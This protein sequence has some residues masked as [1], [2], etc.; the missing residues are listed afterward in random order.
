MSWE[1]ESNDRP[2]EL[3]VVVSRSP[4]LQPATPEL[5]TSPTPELLTS[6]TPAPQPLSLSPLPPTAPST[7]TTITTT[8]TTK[9]LTPP[10]YPLSLLPPRFQAL[11]VH[12][13]QY[14]DDR[15]EEEYVRA[16]AGEVI[17]GEDRTAHPPVSSGLRVRGVKK[18][19]NK[20][21]VFDDAGQMTTVP[22]AEP[23]GKSDTAFEM[24]ESK[25]DKN[26]EEENAEMKD[27]EREEQQDS[28]TGTLIT[29]SPTAASPEPVDPNLT[30]EVDPKYYAQ[31]YRLFS[32]Y[33]AG[34]R[35]DPIGWYSVTPEAIAVHQA[36]RIAASLNRPFSVIDAFCGL[37]GNTIAF[38]LHPLC[39]RVIAIELDPHRLSLARHNAAV[40]GVSDKCEWVSG[41]WLQLQSQL[42]LHTESSAENPSSLQQ[43]DALFLAP[44]W[45]GV[46][47]GDRELYKLAD[48]E[49][50]GGGARLIQDGVR[51]ASV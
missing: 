38:A 50:E 26:G 19:H 32:R 18:G 4:L 9:P 40:Y 33:D 29:T 17:E 36:E 30:A 39:Q 31:R 47:Y 27:A 11:D 34:I 8:T 13:A 16:H 42:L 23:E 24:Q 1:D 49:V 10:L 51:L 45:G 41:D 15:D 22:A 28:A 43:A 3:P 37:G 6:P 7:T 2:D 12:H 46:Q 14:R 25:E 35:L 21:V 5:L 20:R 48:V 44:P